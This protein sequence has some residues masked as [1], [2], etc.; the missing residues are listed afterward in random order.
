MQKHV[1]LVDLVKSFPTIM[2]LQKSA[3]IQPR[4]SLSEFG[5]KFSSLFIRLLIRRRTELE[6]QYF[7]SIVSPKILQQK[8]ARR[9]HR[10]IRDRVSLS[11]RLA[12]FGGVEAG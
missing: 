1:N 12:S 2:Y 6:I 8:Y 11:V 9:T 4:T 7:R 5:G 3:S 10:A